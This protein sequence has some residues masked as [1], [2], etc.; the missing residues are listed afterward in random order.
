[1][2]GVA[3]QEVALGELVVGV[4]VEAGVGD[5]VEEHLRGELRG[6]AVLGHQRQRGG[7][8]AADRVAGDGDAA[9]VEALAGAVCLDP[10]G[11]G[12]VL[13]DRDRVTRLG[14]AV[15]LGEDDGGAGADGELTDEAVV[16]VGVPKTQP[17][18]WM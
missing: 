13:L 15:V 6:A 18:P 7:H 4:G 11:G 14:G 3:A 10:A 1:L 17:A 2:H 8:V 9:R 5:W 12:V 16:G